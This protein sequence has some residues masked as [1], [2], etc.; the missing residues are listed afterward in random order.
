MRFF[1]SII[2]IALSTI[3]H[4]QENS[5]VWSLEKCINYAKLNNIN[6]KQADIQ[7]RA[8]QIQLKQ[9]KSAQH[10][11]LNISSV[12]AVQFG[13]TIDPTTNSFID[14]NLIAS[15]FQASGS[16]PLYFFG[17]IK[18][19]IE[20]E[21]YNFLVSSLNLE[22]ISSEV[23]LTV[24][25][26][27]LRVLLAQE[28]I[29][30]I[31]IEIS[32]TSLQIEK[33]KEAI[34]LGAVSE[35]NLYR[36]KSKL[37]S[38]S[39]NYYDAKNYFKNSLLVLQ[40]VLNLKNII[41]FKVENPLQIKM[42]YPE[43]DDLNNYEQI[44]INALQNSLR[45]KINN[46]QN[47]SYNYK[48]KSSKAIMYPSV[49]L[50]YNINS[51]FSNIIKDK[52]FNKWWEGFGDQLNTNFNQIIGFNINIPV[53]NSRQARSNYEKDK[54]AIQSL[55]LD[56]VNVENDLKQKV[57]SAISNMQTIKLKLKE[58]FKIRENTQI[59]Y[60]K[61]S[62]YFRIGG[63]NVQEIINAQN[64]LLRSNE[65]ILKL[66]IEEYFSLKLLEFYQ[67]GKIN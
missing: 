26:Y 13:K 67:Y 24:L 27:Y 46:A 34:E 50:G 28:Q 58:S 17:G 19:S 39:S 16:L 6:I 2:V 61:M 22:N 42:N 49:S 52:P 62:E 56:K 31:E 3:L 43:V 53:F 11:T 60:D 35:L 48:L 33:L 32:K 36:Y 41:D 37:A 40:A 14:I 18:N 51:V 63:T 7:Q 64:D 9:I 45:L 21:K 38:D 15:R 20:S 10:P 57:S 25:G 29:K 30:L 1:F 44:Y 8:E 66:K 23:S 59:I 54:I 12:Q 47:K 65:L 4:A 55:N 5:E